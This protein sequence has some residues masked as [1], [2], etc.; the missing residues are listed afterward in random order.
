MHLLHAQANTKQ[1]F[2]THKM[3]IG[4][5]HTYRNVQ[6]LKNFVDMY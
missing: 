3:K 1:I 2:M 5:A 6:Q 4:F